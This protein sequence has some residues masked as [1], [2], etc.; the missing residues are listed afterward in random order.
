MDSG[1]WRCLWY[2]APTVCLGLA[3]FKR[4]F[5]VAA[6][7]AP[8]SHASSSS[9][10][11]TF[12]SGSSELF[13]FASAVFVAFVF[14]RRRTLWICAFGATPTSQLIFYVV[15]LSCWEIWS[16]CRRWCFRESKLVFHPAAC[17]WWTVFER[18][19]PPVRLRLWH[20][21]AAGAFLQVNICSCFL[22]ST[23][24]NSCKNKTGKANLFA[25]EMTFF[26]LTQSYTILGIWNKNNLAW[27][28]VII[29][30]EHGGLQL[31]VFA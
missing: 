27:Q 31:R 19:S 9:K 3:S 5:S 1:D 18:E 10:Y 4:R 11:P 25:E 12:F 30:R 22:T 28:S 7:A 20:L 17:R 8:T 23:C 26:L 29:W 16:R 13:L 14:A 24:T 15:G 21:K 6:T 2:I